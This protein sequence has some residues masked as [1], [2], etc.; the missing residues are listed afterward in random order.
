[1]V[2]TFY[3]LKYIL[4]GECELSGFNCVQF[5]ETPWTVAHQGPISMVFP[6]QEYWSGLP[7]PPLGDLPG[8]GIEPAS[9]ELKGR[10]FTTEPPGSPLFLLCFAN[11]LIFSL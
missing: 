10:F 5:F 8:P 4:E 2:T 11:F 9:S 3:D 7:F 6:K 1:M